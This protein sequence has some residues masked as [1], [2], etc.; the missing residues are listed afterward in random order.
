MGSCRD[1]VIPEP[2]EYL[3]GRAACRFGWCGDQGGKGKKE[4][5]LI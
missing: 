1:T 4:D 3:T 2:A 5:F